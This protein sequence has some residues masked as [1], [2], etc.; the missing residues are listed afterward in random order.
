MKFVTRNANAAVFVYKNHKPE[1]KDLKKFK[2]KR[3]H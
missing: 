3:I 2:R 1:N